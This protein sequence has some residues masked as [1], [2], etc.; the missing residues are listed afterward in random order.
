MV[1]GLVSRKGFMLFSPVG[2]K[3]APTVKENSFVCVCVILFFWK[4]P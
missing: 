3:G 2:Q 4:A 1:R